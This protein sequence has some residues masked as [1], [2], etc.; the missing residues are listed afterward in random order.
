LER[1]A[2]EIELDPAGWVDLHGDYLYRFALLRVRVPDVAEELV[3]ESLL[4]ALTARGR[5]RGQCSERSWLTAILKRKVIDW[6]R[7]KVRSNLRREPVPDRWA[8]DL[9]TRGGAW[10]TKPNEWSA[11]DPGRGLTET[12][13]R[14]TLSGCLDKL[15]PR[16]RES[17]V[18]RHV[19]EAGAEEV[20]AAVGASANNLWVMLHRARLRLW[21]C[22]SVNWYGQD[23]ET[24]SE[25]RSP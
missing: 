12:D 19:D 2:I 13:F 23:A 10:K 25:G 11:D 22:L 24:P 5:F 16:L 15:P 20:C 17:F 4:A 9:F 18:L 21:H 14:A 8:D 3:Q 6:L 1:T 7:A